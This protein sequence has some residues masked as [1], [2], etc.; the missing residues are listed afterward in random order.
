[1]VK[2]LV[3]IVK[4]LN[5]GIFI[6]VE[7]FINNGFEIENKFI[8]KILDEMYIE[9]FKEFQKFIVIKEKVDQLVIGNCFFVEEFEKGEYKMLERFVFKFREEV[10]KLVVKVLFFIEKII[11]VI[12]KFV[13][14]KFFIVFEKVLLFEIK[15]KFEEEKM[16]QFVEKK[17]GLKILGKIDLDV[18]N[19]GKKQLAELLKE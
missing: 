4:E 7:Y 17:M 15:V 14:L 1:M 9:F 10:K 13:V 16:E 3:K 6:I 18:F 19:K 2:C 11:F 8:V 12:E 5:V